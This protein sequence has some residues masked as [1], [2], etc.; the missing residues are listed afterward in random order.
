[1]NELFGLHNDFEMHIPF[2]YFSV[3]RIIGYNLRKE[4]N[5]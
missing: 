2:K 1:M 4:I 3:S 5:G